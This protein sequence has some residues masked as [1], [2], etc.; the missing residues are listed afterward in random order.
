MIH[1]VLAFWLFHPL[2]VCAHGG[3]TYDQ[4]LGY[5]FWSGIGSDIGEITV[6]GL[7]LSILITTYR[8]FNC[9]YGGTKILPPDGCHRIGRF[10]H[11]HF[12][13][14]K[15]HHPNVPSDGKITTEHI[16]AQPSHGDLHDVIKDLRKGVDEWCKKL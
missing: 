16:A 9:H 2:G 12:T 1:A 11:G 10:D 13:L 15:N 4:C 8:K 6:I 3:A 14:C 7:V 5:N